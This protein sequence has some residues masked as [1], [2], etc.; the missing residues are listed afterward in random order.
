M[1]STAKANKNKGYR[2]EKQG[3]DHL[4][5][6]FPDIDPEEIQ[7]HGT[8]YGAAD[9]GDIT[10]VPMAFV[11]ELKD[12]QRFDLAQF[13]RELKREIA[14]NPHATNGAVV[15]KARLKSVGDAYSVMPFDQLLKL[16]RE[17]YDLKQLLSE[18]HRIRKEG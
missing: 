16:V 7:R 14:N 12:V 6:T 1:A 3:L 10:I 15:I 11:F 17:N 9:R 4:R 5:A 8:L 18:E 2:W 13:I